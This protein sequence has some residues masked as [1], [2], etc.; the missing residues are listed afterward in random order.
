MLN[1]ATILLTVLP[2]LSS[3]PQPYDERADAGAEVAECCNAPV[4]S[5]SRSC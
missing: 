1:Q 3:L 5:R 2:A 4:P